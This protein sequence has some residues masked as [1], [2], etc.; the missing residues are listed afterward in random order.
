[1]TQPATK[2]QKSPHLPI[3]FALG[4]VAVYLGTKQ[5]DDG[6]PAPFVEI[7]NP[8]TGEVHAD[9]IRGDAAIGAFKAIITHLEN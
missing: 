4:N 6:E 1:M 8:T 5:E 7:I 2:Q 3:Y 9:N